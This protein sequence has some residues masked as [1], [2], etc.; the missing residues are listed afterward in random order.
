MRMTK[1]IT[2]RPTRHW[3]IM[4]LSTGEVTLAQN[5]TEAGK[6]AMTGHGKPARQHPRR[7]GRRI[8]ASSRPCMD[9]TNRRC[10][11]ITYAMPPR[12]ST[13][14]LDGR[15]WRELVATRADDPDGFYELVKALRQQF[16][17]DHLPAGSDG[18]V[19]SVCGRF[20][21][22]A[23]AGELATEWNILPWET[24]E[25]TQAAAICFRA[26]LDERGGIG[27]GEGPGRDPAGA[28]VLRATRDFALSRNRGRTADHQSLR[29][30][31]TRW[32]G[33]GVSR[34]AGGVEIRGLSRDRWRD[35]GKGT[36]GSGAC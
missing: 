2:A 27:A 8:S 3:C 17:S 15:S 10:W 26:W 21:V 4:F 12:P 35:G 22:V 7:R 16:I 5:M 14:R 1:N 23:A 6:R 24:G 34:P 11:R 29:L 30:A 33:L 28:G 32:R 9:S 36:G 13:A 31:A 18:Q 25:A 20:G 19:R